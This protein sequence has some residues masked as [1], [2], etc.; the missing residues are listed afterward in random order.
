M[1]RETQPDTHLEVRLRRDGW[2]VALV[3]RILRRCR[4]ARLRDVHR[5][6]VRE[7]RGGLHVG[8]L[9]ELVHPARGLVDR[10]I[11]EP[12]VDVRHAVVDRGEHL[13]IEVRACVRRP[14][15]QRLAQAESLDRSPCV[16]DVRDE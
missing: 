4:P 12:R 8:L 10:H 9:E 3:T 11:R 7:L 14:D 16:R 1:T 15:R 13:V 5:G 2:P 6:V